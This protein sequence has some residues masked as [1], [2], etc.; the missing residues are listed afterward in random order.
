MHAPKKNT[1]HDE[2]LKRPERRTE[3]GLS[4]HNLALADALD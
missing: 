4:T 3:E 2:S 1:L